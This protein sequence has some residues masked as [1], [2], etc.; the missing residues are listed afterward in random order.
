MKAKETT[1]TRTFT[2]EVNKDEMDILVSLVGYCNAAALG[3]RYSDEA[4]KL[5]GPMY[6]AMRTALGMGEDELPKYG[7]RIEQRD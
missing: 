5:L 6:E 2:L 7:L 4:G 1:T 3:L